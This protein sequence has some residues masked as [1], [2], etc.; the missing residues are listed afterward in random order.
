M[1]HVASEMNEKV[2]YALFSQLLSGSW[3]VCWLYVMPN[4]KEA[5]REV[6]VKQTIN[7]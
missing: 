3:S 5:G 4:G 7:S 6:Y 1:L 2:M